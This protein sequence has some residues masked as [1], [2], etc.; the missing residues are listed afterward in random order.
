MAFPWAF[1]NACF[2]YAI[3]EAENQ[4]FN[5]LQ[6]SHVFMDKTHTQKKNNFYKYFTF[7]LKLLKNNHVVLTLRLTPK[8]HVVVFV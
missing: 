5:T 2:T 7:V 4:N 8:L 3:S 1:S 6:T